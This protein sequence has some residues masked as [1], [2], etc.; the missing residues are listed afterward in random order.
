M[1][2]PGGAPAQAFDVLGLVEAIGDAVVVSDPS[3]AIVVWNAA[4]TRI[5]GH[6]AAEAMGQS[7]DLITPERQ[8]RR[9]WDGYFETMRTGITKYGADVLRVPA[10]HKDGHAL[11]IAFTVGL[12]HRPDGAV[13]GIAAII[14]DETRR[15]TE[16]RDLRRRVAELESRVLPQG[17]V[18]TA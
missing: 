2:D 5:F 11:S 16:E 12:L 14:R 18:E 7:L 3:G 1:A 8:R 9:H 10:I 15:W 13:T 4:A 17:A 6:T